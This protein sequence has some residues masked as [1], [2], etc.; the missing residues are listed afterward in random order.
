VLE[1][2][3]TGGIVGLGGT[4]LQSGVA[5]AAPPIGLLLV[6]N[7]ALALFSCATPHA[8]A[9]SVGL[10]VSVGRGRPGLLGA[11][12][13][14]SRVYS[15]PSSRSRGRPSPSPPRRPSPR[16]FCRRASPCRGAGSSPTGAASIPGRDSRSC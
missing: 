12:P 6:L 9:F 15:G 14:M 5:L 10:P 7:V 16:S 3:V 1:P 11:G 4:V 2:A 13:P 8:P